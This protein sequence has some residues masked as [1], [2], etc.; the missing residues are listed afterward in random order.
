MA[1]YCDICGNKLGL[2]GGA[3]LNAAPEEL[4][5]IRI[6]DNCCNAI[7]NLPKYDT[8]PYLEA[9]KQSIENEQLKM[10]ISELIEQKSN[11][12]ETLKS[13]S[14][15][16]IMVTS[17]YNY[18]GYKI[19][20]YLGFISSEIVLGMGAIKSQLASFSNLLGTESNALGAKLTEA[21]ECTINNL[22]AQAYN[23]G[24]NAIIGINL[25]YTMFETSMVAVIVS[26]TAVHIE[27][28]QNIDAH[29]DTPLQS[30]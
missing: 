1:S 3:M 9:L 16:G 24:A 26:G 28:A 11:N 12:P 5:K 2:G 8:V 27:S 22:K 15:Q 4:R 21:K 10:Y 19:M 6:C 17:G 23:L 18:E 7:I 13:K 25:N 20:A 14:V 29:I 30:A